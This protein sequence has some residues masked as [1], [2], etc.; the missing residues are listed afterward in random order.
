LRRNINSG[1]YTIYVSEA[2]EYGKGAFSAFGTRNCDEPKHYPD[3]SALA[4]P[5]NW[6][7]LWGNMPHRQ[8]SEM[9]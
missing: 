6:S 5:M 7:F 3:A 9:A 1:L 4:L 8:F 2:H